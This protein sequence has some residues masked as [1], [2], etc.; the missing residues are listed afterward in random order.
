M[1]PDMK[2][3]LLLQFL[4]GLPSDMATRLARAVEMD[5]L[6]DG[7]AL[8]HQTILDGLR[9]VLRGGPV[10]T[11]TL[12]PLRLF[13]R[14]FEDILTSTR[15]KKQKASLARSSV[16]PTWLWLSRTLI[17]GPC[18]AF[19]AETKTLILA[20][21]PDE[22]NVRAA[23]FWTLAGQTMRE[24]VATEAGRKAAR[25]ALNGDAVLADAEEMALLLL[26]GPEVCRVQALLPKP[27]PHLNDDL[28]WQLR[29]I[30]DELVSRLPDAAPYVAVLTMNRLARPWEALK[31]PLQISRSKA[32]TLISKTDMGLVGEI[33]FT[34]MEDLQTAIIGTRPSNFDPDK[35]IEQVSSFA[36]LSSAIVK[37]IEVRRDGEWGQRLLRERGAIGDV[38]DAFMDKALKE[39]S[40]ALPVQKGSGS[41]RPADFSRALDPD[42]QASALRL[43]RLVAGSRH[44]A[45]AASFAAKQKA[46]QDDMSAYMRR[47]NEDLVRE[48]RCSDPV[49]KANA[50]A[51]FEY[52]VEL[53]TLLM[54]EEEAEILRRRAR[55]A[56]SAAA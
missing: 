29:A 43:A 19:V 26:A 10:P 31:L 55:A 34:R 6:M 36:E 9:P 1:L 51:Q 38:M 15:S 8:P 53:V 46:A 14:P 2:S 20:Q 7:K 30:Y 5:R 44:F 40:M 13:C 11:R 25:I 48:L 27:V 12:T 32:D 42:R 23:Q 39:L 56:L 35:L 41:S 28:L 17:P 16:L 50:E 3:G 22:A 37:E 18:Q 21:R 52:C 45:A 54:G 4:G 24:A 33:L 47:H 49:R